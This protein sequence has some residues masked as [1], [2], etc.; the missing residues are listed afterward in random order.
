M[1]RIEA[2]RRASCGA[3]NNSLPVHEEL[4]TEEIED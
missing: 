2:I 4:Q 3:L 1:L